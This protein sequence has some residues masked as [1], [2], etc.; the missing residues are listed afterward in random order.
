MALTFTPQTRDYLRPASADD[1]REPTQIATGAFIGSDGQVYY[2]YNASEWAAN[3][4]HPVQS[5]IDH[6]RPQIEASLINGGNGQQYIPASVYEGATNTIR[7]Y[8]TPDDWQH[9]LGDALVNAPVAA[10]LGALGAGAYSLAGGLSAA[11]SAVG[12]AEGAGAAG[13]LGGGAA[14]DISAL[15]QPGLGLG[16][17]DVLGTGL[18]TTPSFGAT[19][20]AL[21]SA[22]AGAGPLAANALS[23]SQL[24]AM[25]AGA[26]NL[27]PGEA[28]TGLGAGFKI[29]GTD[30]TVPGNVLAGGLQAIGGWIGADKMGD[31]YRDVAAQQGQIGAPFRD[32]LLQSYQPGFDLMSQPGYGD[33]F[34]QIADTSTR[35]W[36]G[37]GVNPANN[38]GA[39]AEIQNDVW[40]RGYLPALSNYR[41]G[42]GQWGGLGLN[43]SGAASLASAGAVGDQWEA[44]GAG[45][46]TALNPQPNWNDIFKQM[47]GGKLTIGGN[48]VGR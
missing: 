4:G 20:A 46:N 35:A 44:I 18:A 37:R 7:P 47:S 32:L 19:G 23:S 28:S 14:L 26:G 27:L 43:T 2:P 6:F 29:P 34:K 39:Q 30:I 33:A 48:T 3:S 21:G 25:G 40:T 9:Q 15:S 1:Q 22:A 11:P 42:L 45:A 8:V 17:S 38:P 5:L 41:G 36:S 16:T 10:G 12:A 24:A 31:A 13:G